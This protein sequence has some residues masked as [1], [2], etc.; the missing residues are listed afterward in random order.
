MNLK[1]RGYSMEIGH[2]F[3]IDN[4]KY[5]ICDIALYG[6]HKYAYTIS[7]PKDDIKFD[8]FEIIEDAEG[9]DI[10]EV[11]SKEIINELIKIFVC[12]E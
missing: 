2:V 11:T 4:N 12:K 1:E 6:N 8:Y 3:E 7:G 9:Y 10:E 5:C